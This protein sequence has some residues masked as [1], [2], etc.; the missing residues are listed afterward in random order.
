MA[1]ALIRLGKLCGRG[2]LLQ[3]A[4]DIVQLAAG[5]M[6]RA[7]SGV[8][9]ML[10]AADM[11]QGP[12]YELVIVGEPDDDAT[13]S[14]VSDL[15]KRY[16]PNRVVARRA[17]GNAGKSPALADLFAGKSA[18][19]GQPTLFICEDFACSSPVSGTVDIGRALA[20]LEDDSPDRGA[21]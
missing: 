1:S 5:L 21:S 11:L 18:E 20:E 6:Q 4:A 2:D 3:A 19:D 12:F 8:G 10:V 7:P 9:Q 17:S 13:R 16:L 15:R 14:V